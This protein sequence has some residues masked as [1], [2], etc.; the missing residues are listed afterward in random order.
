[1]NDNNIKCMICGADCGMQVSRQHLKYQHNMTTT[2]YKAL[3]YET[4]SPAR[5]RQLMKSPIA[6]GNVKR[7]YGEDHH[8][9]KGG[10]IARSGYKIISKR[11]KTNQYEHRVIAEEMI[12]RPLLPDEVVHH[13]DGNRSNNTAENL[14]VMKR[15]DH[16]KIKDG[17]RAHFYTNEDC[18]AA[19]IDLYNLGW[20]KIRLE[21]ALRIHHQTL[22]NWLHKHSEKLNR[23]IIVNSKL[24][25]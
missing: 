18:E 7:L 8:N 20:S 10:H 5:L 11:G 15:Q 3:G 16:D 14:V 17:T 1:M 9:W 13:K 12:G 19:A 24:R 23:P 4:L 2:E 6:K 25:E 21:R 22:K